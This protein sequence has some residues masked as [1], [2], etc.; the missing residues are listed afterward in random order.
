MK[1][2][3]EIISIR[4]IPI[5]KLVFVLFLAFVSSNETQIISGKEYSYVQEYLELSL[6]IIN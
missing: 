5:Q 4:I 1:N 2:K 6:T 3:K